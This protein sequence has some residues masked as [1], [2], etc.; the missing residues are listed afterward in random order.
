MA[1]ARND[2]LSDHFNPQRRAHQRNVD[3]VH[4]KDF[5]DN[6]DEDTVQDVRSNLTLLLMIYD[7]SLIFS[8]IL[9]QFQKPHELAAK[10]YQEYYLRDGL[11][12]DVPS[13][14]HIKTFL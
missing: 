1:H 7:L 11:E 13:R 6:D 8:L 9:V 12:L 5:T 3:T 14:R 10:T 4:I 2:Q